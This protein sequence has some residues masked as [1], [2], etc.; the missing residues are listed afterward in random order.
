MQFSTAEEGLFQRYVAAPIDAHTLFEVDLNE[1]PVRC[2]IVVKDVSH[3]SHLEALDVDRAGNRH[4][5]HVRAGHEIA[6]DGAEQVDP[7]QVIDTQVKQCQ[8]DDRHKADRHL[9]GKLHL[10]ISVIDL[11]LSGYFSRFPSFMRIMKALGKS[12]WSSRWSRCMSLNSVVSPHVYL[13]L[14]PSR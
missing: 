5:L 12:F 6:V 1:Y 14:P 8:A 10:H 7:L 13:Y 11:S 9:F 4:V 3:Q 2:R